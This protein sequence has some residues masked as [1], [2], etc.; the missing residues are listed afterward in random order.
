MSWSKMLSDMG[1]RNLEADE[2]W[3]DSVKSYKGG[4]D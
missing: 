2:G 1:K 3:G 4:S